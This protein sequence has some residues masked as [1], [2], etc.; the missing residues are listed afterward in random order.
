MAEE[1]GAIILGGGLSGENM[2]GRTGPGELPSLSKASWLAKSAATGPA[3]RVRRWQAEGGSWP[4]LAGLPGARK[5]VI[6]RLD[7]AAGPKRRDG[8]LGGF[9]D[10][11]QVR[12]LDSVKTRGC[13]GARSASPDS[14]R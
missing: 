3:C 2:A 10:Q 8:F 12:R 13:T 9:N 7:V 11:G 6:G 4:L 14:R 1:Y 5:A